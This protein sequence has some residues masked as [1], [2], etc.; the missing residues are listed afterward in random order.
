MEHQVNALAIIKKKP[1]K[2][3]AMEQG[4]GKTTIGIHACEQ[5]ENIKRVLII[6]PSK[7]I[8]IWKDEYAKWFPDVKVLAYSG[9]LADENKVIVSIDTIKL[10]IHFGKFASKHWDIVIVDEAQELC[11]A[12]SKQSLVLVPFIKQIPRVLLLTG[13]P[14]RNRPSELFNL[15]SMI[16]PGTFCNR[17]AFTT[18]FCD[19]HY[20]KFKKWEERGATNVEE[21][22]ELLGKY[23]IRATKAQVLKN[24]PRCTEEIVE[25][26]QTGSFDLTLRETRR[27]YMNLLTAYNKRPSRDKLLAVQAKVMEWWRLSGQAKAE[28]FIEW[29][30]P[31]FESCAPTDKFL[32]WCEHVSV[33]KKLHQSIVENLGQDCLIVTG[34]NSTPLNRKHMFK[35]L[36]SLDHPLRIGICNYRSCQDSL[37]IT[38]GPNKIIFTEFPWTYAT[39]VQAKARTHRIGTIREILYMYLKLAGSHDELAIRKLKMK[40]ELFDAIVDGCVSHS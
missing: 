25:M 14:Q 18:K 37:T 19:G 17:K 28:Y 12:T 23:M 20:N 27:E 26:T 21:L 7:N 35:N 33:A 39:K 2:I 38:P 13:T 15:L 24:L 5:T 9:E 32:I 11:G 31:Y 4:L 29:F 8:V 30:K 3:L 1:R 36:N 40:E 6:V 16:D 10:K 22:H 34:E